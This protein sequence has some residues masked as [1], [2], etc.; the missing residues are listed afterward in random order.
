MSG[1]EFLTEKIIDFKLCTVSSRKLC[2]KNEHT[3][4]TSLA[5]AGTQ[6]SVQWD[7]VST[8][9]GETSLFNVAEVIIEQA[10]PSM[11]LKR[12]IAIQVRQ[13]DVTTVLISGS[14]MHMWKLSGRNHMLK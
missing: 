1:Q 10:V 6:V 7:K 2:L 13:H 9:S 12:Y 8:N 4:M 14:K 5:A 11:I 3:V